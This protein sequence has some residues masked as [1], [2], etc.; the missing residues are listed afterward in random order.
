MNLRFTQIC[1]DE[2]RSHDSD[3]CPD[4]PVASRQRAQGLRGT[5]IFASQ[6]KFSPRG[7]WRVLHGS[8]RAEKG[9]DTSNEPYIG[10][11][12]DQATSITVRPRR[13]NTTHARLEPDSPQ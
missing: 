9:R 12:E 3:S 13:K 7:N 1:I 2:L 10:L 11:V 6:Q 4:G 5:L 8:P